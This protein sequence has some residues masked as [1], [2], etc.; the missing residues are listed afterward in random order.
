MSSEERFAA[1]DH[2]A[3]GK[4]FTIDTA[5]LSNPTR[6]ARCHRIP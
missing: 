4:N 2:A 3:E 6:S 1:L 5:V